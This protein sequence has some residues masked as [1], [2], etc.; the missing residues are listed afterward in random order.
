MERIQVIFYPGTFGNTLRWLLDRFS[1]ISNFKNF[2]SPW[3]KDMRAHGFKKEDFNKKFPGGHESDIRWGF[4]DADKIVLSFEKN[5]IVFADRC[6]Y[7]RSPKHET[8]ESRHAAI[9]NLA[10]STL[11]ECFGKEN[12]ASKAVAKELYKIDYHH[13]LNEWWRRIFEFI[14]N[15]ENFQFPLDSMWN[16]KKLTEELGK[17]SDRFHLNLE[18]EERVIDNVVNVIENMSVVKT[19]DRVKDVLEA[20]QNKILIDCGDLDIVEQAFI[21]ATLEKKYDSILFPY[22]YNW[23]KDTNQINEFI[24]TYP[25]YLKHMNPR[26]PWYNGI[27]NPYYLTGKIKNESIN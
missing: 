18:I 13:G 7:Y 3:D 11:K 26:L 12:T 23:F 21:E 4:P 5:E 1:P 9:I 6:D 16:K 15:K 10:N 25:S 24:D 22:G 14:D 8:E 27:K 17:V 2:D 20:I 19:K